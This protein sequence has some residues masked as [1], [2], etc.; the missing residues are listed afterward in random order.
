MV[1][2]SSTDSQDVIVALGTAEEN[3]PGEIS[4]ITN[5]VIPDIADA[6]GSINTVV[7]GATAEIGTV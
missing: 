3:A 1:L 6:L 4:N 5:I 2:I 7:S